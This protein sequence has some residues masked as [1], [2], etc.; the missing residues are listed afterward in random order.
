M[1]PQP[2]EEHARGP[3]RRGEMLA[4]AG[5]LVLCL[6]VAAAGGAV[7]AT[8][9][10][11]WYQTLTKPS[12]NPPDWVFAPVWTTLFVLMAVA[13]WRV[14]RRRGHPGRALALTLFG[15]QL[16]LNLLWSCLFFGLQ[17]IGAALVEVV[18]LLGAILATSAM[19]S[20]I[21]RRAAWLMVPYAAWVSFAVL[22]NTSIWM[23]N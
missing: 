8:S 20:R 17:A 23:L 22:L 3:G 4:L 5:F 6:A 14:W 15:V 1:A 13:G 16:A 10:D 18:M 19:F 21:D 11:G 7:T 12:F 9:V 2:N